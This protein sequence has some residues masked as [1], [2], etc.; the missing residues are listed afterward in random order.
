MPKTNAE[1]QRDYRKN[2][3]FAGPNRDGD[4]RIN[5]WVSSA[6]VFALDRLARRYGVTKR[7]MLEMLIEQADEKIRRT[8]DLDSPE[9]REYFGS[10]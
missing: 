9:W 2:R 1:R 5:T 10:Y 6:T 4:M 7:K 3:P 8:L